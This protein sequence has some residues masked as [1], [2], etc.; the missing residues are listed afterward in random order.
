[1]KLKQLKRTRHITLLPRITIGK[2]GIFYL[3][4]P[5]IKLI[6][7]DKNLRMASIYQ[8]EEDKDKFFLKISNDGICMI[9]NKRIE[10]G[11]AKS[12]TFSFMEGARDINRH[13]K[14][15]NKNKPLRFKVGELVVINKEHYFPLHI[16]RHSI[17]TKEESTHIPYTFNRIAIKS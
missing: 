13:F 16:V 1:M 2:T 4:R 11:I 6:M 12:A 17:V 8:D 7:K 15:I 10:K 9:T 14:H 3:N 5:A